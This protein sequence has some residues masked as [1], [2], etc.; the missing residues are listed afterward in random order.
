M[1]YCGIC[2]VRLD[3]YIKP[4]YPGP[5]P[6]SFAS[7]KLQKFVMSDSPTSISAG[8]TQ[9][10]IRISSQYHNTSH[11]YIG[12]LVVILQEYKAAYSQYDPV[13]FVSCKSATD[14]NSVSSHLIYPLDGVLKTSGSLY[15]IES[16]LS[17]A[18]FHAI[19]KPRCNER[20]VRAKRGTD[21]RYITTEQ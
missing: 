1:Y 6:A 19:S 16:P 7:F 9:I 11:F 10:S 4:Q 2:G 14:Q 20:R 21:T 17:S 12:F 13:L 8:D 18:E 3:C 5:F 15:S